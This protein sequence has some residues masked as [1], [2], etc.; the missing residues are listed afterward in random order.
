MG[1]LDH[2]LFDEL[3]LCVEVC[4]C[5]NAGMCIKCSAYARDCSRILCSTRRFVFKCCA[6]LLAHFRILR[7]WHI[8]H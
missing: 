1:I 5:S 6:V 7:V 4:L 8:F 2:S 3:C